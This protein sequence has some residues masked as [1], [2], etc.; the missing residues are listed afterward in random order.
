MEEVGLSCLAVAAFFAAALDAAADLL[1][2]F[3]DKKR[4]AAGRASLVDWAIP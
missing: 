4:G 2:D 3:L 1:A